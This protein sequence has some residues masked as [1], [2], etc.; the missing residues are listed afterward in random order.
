MAGNTVDIKIEAHV[1]VGEMRKMEEALQREIVQLRLAGNEM[2][3]LTAKEGE[4]LAMRKKIAA[5][6]RESKFRAAAHEVGQS[7]P[8]VGPILT[9]INGTAGMVGGV[10]LGVSAAFKLAGASIR[11]FAAS[12][13]EMAKLDAALANSGNLTDA[14]REKLAKLATER[15]GKTGIDDEKYIGVF[16]TLTKFG[17]NTGNIDKYTTAVENL[18]GFM[19]GDMDQAAFL[20]GKAMQGST[21][22]LGRYGIGVD[23]S[24]SQ[25]EQL[26]DIMQQLSARGGGQLEAMA[27]TLE[28]SFKKI[29]NAW[30][31]M[32]EGFGSAAEKAGLANYFTRFAE[33]LQ[34]I[35]DKIGGGA[36]PKSENRTELV[37]ATPEEQKAADG[38]S[39]QRKELEKLKLLKQQDSAG[40]FDELGLYSTGPVNLLGKADREKKADLETRI[41]SNDNIISQIDAALANLDAKE[42]TLNLQRVPQDVANKNRQDLAFKSDQKAALAAEEAKA[43]FASMT[44][45]E[46]LADLKNQ[47]AGADK[48]VDAAVGEEEKNAALKVQVELYGKILSLG[49][50]IKKGAESKA[51]QRTDMLLDQK[52]ARA[53]ETGNKAEELR[54]KWAKQYNEERRKAIAAGM[55]ENAAVQYGTDEANA[56]SAGRGYKPDQQ[57]NLEKSVVSAM[58]AVGTGR[59]EV[60][61]AQ[62]KS[63]SEIQKTNAKLDKSN[64]YLRQ[65]QEQKRGFQ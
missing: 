45:Q 10:M 11:A 30:E 40:A 28:G 25:S 32:L 35:A 49:A 38:I 61:A 39:A 52:I 59:G 60:Y 64:E 27:N 3:K 51:S 12:E 2:A 20:F 56:G 18:A 14:Y 42:K 29:G 55:G 24:K 33:G 43:R 34:I 17:A 19:G 58:H 54:L 62:D 16:T 53:A 37:G 21:E 23:K 50:A 57:K 13:V 63:L 31:N 1:Q 5:L 36:P 4:L 9:A 7:I 47:K 22:M 15:S 8:G 6:P 65:I 46:Q 41:G 44:P 26:A 48:A